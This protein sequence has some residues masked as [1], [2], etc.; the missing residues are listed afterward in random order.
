MS[1]SRHCRVCDGW[2]E[3]DKSWPHNCIAHFGEK[4]QRSALPVPML[5]RDCM[6][7]TMNP[8]NGQMYESKSDYYRAVRAAGCEIVGND[9]RAQ[10]PHVD[11]DRE[12]DLTPDVAQA[13]NALS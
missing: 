3:L 11:M 4:P 13:F 6:D 8:V 1:R 9:P 7:A 10:Q 5:I 12:A 2:H